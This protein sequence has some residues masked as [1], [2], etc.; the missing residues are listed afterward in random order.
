MIQTQARGLPN[1]PDVPLHNEECNVEKR[2]KRRCRSLFSP[3][4]I[5][6]FVF[7]L[8]LFF[9]FHLALG[10]KIHSSQC[11][12]GPRIG[13]YPRRPGPIP[14]G[15]NPMVSPSR[16]DGTIT[17]PWSIFCTNHGP[18]NTKQKPVLHYECASCVL[19]HKLMQTW[20]MQTRIC[21]NSALSTLSQSQSVQ[22]SLTPSGRAS[23]CSVQR[24]QVLF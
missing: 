5:S 20:D 24:L 15:S 4:M 22:G 18:G 16:R 7:F 23:I 2:R 12:G 21:A 3:L 13:N 14:C 8:F 10:W 1:L 11:S 9:S 6:F 19:N 17:S